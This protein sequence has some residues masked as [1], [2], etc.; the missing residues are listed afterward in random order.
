MIDLH[1]QLFKLNL[2]TDTASIFIDQSNCIINAKVKA[3]LVNDL[4][5]RLALLVSIKTQETQ[6]KEYAI[7]GRGNEISCMTRGFKYFLCE[8]LK[9]PNHLTDFPKFLS[10]IPQD[11]IIGQVLLKHQY[12]NEQLVLE[13]ASLPTIFP[14]DMRMVILRVDDSQSALSFSSKEPTLG[15]KFDYADEIRHIRFLKAP[16]PAFNEKD[17]E[18][19]SL[20]LGVTTY[21]KDNTPTSNFSTQNSSAESLIRASSKGFKAKL[22]RLITM[23]KLSLIMTNIFFAASCMTVNTIVKNLT[24]ELSSNLDLSHQ[25]GMMSLNVLNLAFRAKELYLMN[26]GISFE[27]SEEVVR[28]EILSN[29][30]FLQETLGEFRQDITDSEN[31]DNLVW[32]NYVTGHYI[33]E[34]ESLYEI[35]LQME[36]AAKKLYDTPIQEITETNREFLALY[37]NGPAEVT[38]ALNNT[39]SGFVEDSKATVEETNTLIFSMILIS[40][41]VYISCVFAFSV[42]LLLLI[43]TLRW[44]LWSLLAKLPISIL[45]VG[46]M[47]AAERLHNLHSIEE[48]STTSNDRLAKD[49][50]RYSSH[51]CQMMT[52][53]CMVLLLAGLGVYIYLMQGITG[54]ELYNVLKIKPDYI[55]WA[56]M[57]R[58]LAQYSVFWMR[59]IKNPDPLFVTYN[60][61]YDEYIST[62]ESIQKFAYAHKYIRKLSPPVN[63]EHRNFNFNYGCTAEICLPVLELGLQ[64]TILEMQYSGYDF[65]QHIMNGEGYKESGGIAFEKNMAACIASIIASIKIYQQSTTDTMDTAVNSMIQLTVVF[66]VIV[67]SF[68]F[69]V[70]RP[71]INQ[72]QSDFRNELDIPLM[73]PKDELGSFI[74]ELRN[75][76]KSRK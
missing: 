9:V 54:T 46:K 33:E 45:K 4:E 35:I 13:T 32:I 20:P 23:L 61:F 27:N 41:A 74:P 25:F 75:W 58:T 52:Y 12:G 15:F 26:K 19:E 71:V 39:I 63:D 37:R 40:G 50:I 36:T 17:H 8:E 42:P 68:Y 10:L 11:W 64:S 76:N 49:R 34:R 44:R 28:A 31:A 24:D 6:S 73:L 14:V 1:T 38:R 53:C 55:H 69:I 30:G 67:F 2:N 48:E 57:R 59:E 29:I 18:S 70:I 5:G 65:V 3:S 16:K 56:D 62:I 47:R 7:L 21:I 51:P 60:F 22:G 66:L 72:F 43:N